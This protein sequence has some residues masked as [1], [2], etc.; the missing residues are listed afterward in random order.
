MKLGDRVFVDG[1]ETEIVA[2][3]YDE[4]GTKIY[5]LQNSVKDFY[6]EELI[7]VTR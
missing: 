1:Q 5:T 3:S 4:S 7:P 6:E 2:V